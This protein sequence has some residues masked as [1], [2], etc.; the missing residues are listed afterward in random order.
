MGL[1]FF[2]L[3]MAAK[4]AKELPSPEQFADRQINQSTKIYDRTGET[5]LYEI[6]GEEKRTIVPFEEIPDFVKQAT[7]SVEDREFYSHKAFDWRAII[8]ALFVNII[9]GRVVQ[10]GS[11]ITQQL[12]KNAFLSPERTYERKLKELILAYWI[13]QRYS[14]DEILNLYLNQI[15][16]GANAYGIESASR[17]YFNKSAKD[18]NLAEAAILAALPKAPSYYSPW[19]SHKEELE[20]RKVYILEQ[21]FKSGFIDEEEKERAGNSKIKF[22]EQNIGLIKA[23]HFVM[24]VKE[25]LVEKYGEE[26]LEKGGLNVITTLDWKFQK[27]AEQTIEDGAKRNAELYDGR[28]AALV[29]QDPK[30]GQILALVGSKDYLAEPEPIGCE[31]GKTCQFEGNFN[32]AS[33]ALRQPGSAFKPLAYITAFQKGY[34]PETVVFDLPTEFSTYGNTCP[35]TG[36]N[37]FDNN[38]LCFHPENFDRQFRGPVNLRNALAQSINVPSVKVLYLAG[39][40]DSIKTAQNFGITT[41]T[42][43]SRYGLSLVLGGGEVKLI[44]LVGAYSVFAQEG[45]KHRQAFILEVKNSQGKVLEKYL[46][47]ATQIIEPQYAKLINNILSDAEARSPLFQNSLN[48]TV[49][50]GREAALKTGTTNDYRDAWTI[51][52]TPSLIVGVWAGNNNNKPMQKQAG[53][54]LAAIP[55]WHDFMSK[56]LENYPVEFFNKAEQINQTKPMLN[57]EYIFNNETHNILYYINKNDPLGPQPSSP[58]TDSQFWNWELP[59]K[60]WW[61]NLPG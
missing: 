6:H 59:I 60:N 13:E 5:L 21:M 20:Q 32:V 9:K 37:F 25:F 49:F 12:A 28:N 31:P 14:K 61:Q 16:Y 55:I 7:I 29:A 27:A 10:G 43:P 36:I 54:I 38:S 52:Y 26:I 11:T 18:L 51:G 17:T 41:L 42:D 34:S 39:I 58:E 1:A 35:L 46:D 30:T 50:E 53:S 2:I 15:S 23:P 47:Q 8:R 3:M 48:L 22:S 40:N 45:V 4:I 56:V 57:G 44:D 24:M 19:G 33:Q